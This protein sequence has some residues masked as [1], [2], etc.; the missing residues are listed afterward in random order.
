MKTFIYPNIGTWNEHKST[1]VHIFA[2]VRMKG[3]HYHA[4]HN[5]CIR[6]CLAG[7]NWSE[8]IFR[9]S[10]CWWLDFQDLETV[11]IHKL[12]HLEEIHGGGEKKPEPSECNA[13]SVPLSYSQLTTSMSLLWWVHCKSV[14]FIPGFWISVFL[15]LWVPKLHGI[16]VLTSWTRPESPF[17]D[18]R[19]VFWHLERLKLLIDQTHRF[20]DHGF[21][22]LQ[23]E[24]GQ[25]FLADTEIQL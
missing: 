3:Q 8:E 21:W 2:R 15:S 23:E 14:L 4:V 17:S 6:S 25:G 16:P 18:V 22:Y 12:T 20:I 7:N 9:L 24:S 1:Y 5:E 10:D 19:E 13:S 11:K